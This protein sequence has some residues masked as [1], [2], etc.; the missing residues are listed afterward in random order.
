MNNPS[1][2]ESPYVLFSG[3]S[4]S[5]Y[6]YLITDMFVTLVELSTLFVLFDKAIMYI[7]CVSFCLFWFKNEGNLYEIL[8]SWIRVHKG[9]LKL[10]LVDLPQ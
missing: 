4:I 7:L 1:I 6:N 3:F 9:N 8:G 2:L 5:T 10:V